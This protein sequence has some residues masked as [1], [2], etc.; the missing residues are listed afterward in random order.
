MNEETKDMNRRRFLKVGGSVLVGALFAG[1]VG[2]HLWKMLTR[3]EELF[4][5]HEEMKR[6]EAKQAM[7]DY[8]SPYRLTYGFELPDEVLAMDVME[9]GMLVLCTPNNIW[10]YGLDG[11]LKQNFP[12]RGNVRDLATYN[13]RIYLLYPSRIEVYDTDGELTQQWQAC[14][15]D[16]DYCSMTVFEQGVYAT[17]ASAKNIC[18]YDLAGTLRGFIQSPL[19]FIVPSYSFGITHQGDYL[20]CSNPG[21]HLVEQYTADGHFVSSFGKS[22]TTAGA[23][24]GCCNPVRLA[25]SPTGELL[26]SEKGIPRISCYSADGSFRS[27]LLDSKAL[28]GGH[29]AYDMQMLGDKLVVTGGKK[30]SVF[31][32]DERRAAGTLC[33]NCTVACPLRVLS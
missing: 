7:E 18:H 19:G 8:V 29:A 30:V 6:A 25:A 14:S 3:P 12:V 32:Y 4:F 9:D 11:I 15:D 23:F 33:G 24:S 20:Y 16:A 10:L 1:G 17:D 21:R 13:H 26:T 28:G 31:Q 5:D 27:I 22:G 2:H